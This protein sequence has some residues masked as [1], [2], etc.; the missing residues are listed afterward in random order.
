MK[1]GWSSK[2]NDHNVFM[3]V[4]EKGGYHFPGYHVDSVNWLLSERNVV[5]IG[6]DTASD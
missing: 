3:G 5:G 2:F 6:I 1:T 4:D